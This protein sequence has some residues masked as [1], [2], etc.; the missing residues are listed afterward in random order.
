MKRRLFSNKLR[1]ILPSDFIVSERQK[2]I[3][4]DLVRIKYISGNK[5]GKLALD[6]GLHS[7]D[8]PSFHPSYSGY[9]MACNTN[10]SESIKHEIKG[11]MTE[12]NFHFSVM[13]VESFDIK[14]YQFFY[15]NDITLLK[16][17]II[18]FYINK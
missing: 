11:N 18:F 6:I 1:T 7:Y 8:L 3:Q 17:N 10:Y 12:I 9:I 14:D 15:R 2:F 5:T 13:G 16:L 4:F